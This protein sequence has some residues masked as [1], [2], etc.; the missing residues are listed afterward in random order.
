MGISPPTD[1]VVDVMQ[2]A[3]SS[4]VREVVNKLKSLST[5]S[6]ADFGSAMSE[7]AGSS[8]AV[9]RSAGTAGVGRVGGLDEDAQARALA[10]MPSGLAFSGTSLTALRNAHALSGR[11]APQVS[12]THLPSTNH[13]QATALKKFEGMVLAKFLDEMMPQSSSVFGQGT[14]GSAWKSMLAEKI[15]DNIASVGGI[16]IAANIARASANRGSG[17]R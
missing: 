1:L 3:Q 12:T 7:S 2:N 14:A 10:A 16:G 9:A 15:G 8:P 17:D 11:S 13:A 6:S 4:R 5:N